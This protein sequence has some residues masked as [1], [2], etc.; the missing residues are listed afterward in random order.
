MTPKKRMNREEIS[1]S[2]PKATIDQCLSLKT[3]LILLCYSFSFPLWRFVLFVGF[4]SWKIGE[5]VFHHP[6]RNLEEAPRMDPHLCL[7]FIHFLHCR[8]ITVL[9]RS[10]NSHFRG[11]CL[12][13]IN[14]VL[15]GGLRDCGF[16]SFLSQHLNY[17]LTNTAVSS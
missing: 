6:S 16:W 7:E 17:I 15:W 4:F 1:V 5:W 10:I 2:H 14:N 13:K 9:Q 11:K 3:S 12:T 8:I